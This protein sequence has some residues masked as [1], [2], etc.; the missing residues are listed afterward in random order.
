[1]STKDTIFAYLDAATESIVEL[2]SLLTAIPAIAPE[3]GGEGEA[4]KAEAPPGMARQ[5]GP[6][7]RRALRLARSARAWRHAPQLRRHHP[8]RARGGGAAL[9]HEPSRRGARGRALAMVHRS[10]P[11]RAQGRQDLRPRGRGQPARAR[12]LGLRRPRLP[13][14]RHK[15]RAHHKAP[16]RRRRGG[17]IRA[18]HP[19]HPRGGPRALSAGRP[20]HGPPTAA[21]RTAPRSRWPR[22]ISAGSR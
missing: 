16:L 4:R 12:E 18:R 20:H 19:A 2:E 21:R 3:S 8:R 7:A 14:E 9:D 17:G 13:R 1:M 22:R 5:E 10:L 11:R 6:D 15:E